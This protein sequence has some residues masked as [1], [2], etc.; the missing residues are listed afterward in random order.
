[1]ITS[2]SQEKERFDKIVQSF[3]SCSKHSGA[4]AFDAYLC[5]AARENLNAIAAL[6]GKPLFDLSSLY[7]EYKDELPIFQV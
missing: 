1:M 5:A 3:E 6:Q 4:I 7:D 2:I